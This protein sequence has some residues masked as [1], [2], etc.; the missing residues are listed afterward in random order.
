MNIYFNFWF[1]IIL[2]FIGLIIFSVKK[3]SLNLFAY[4]I[5]TLFTL[6]LVLNINNFNIDFFLVDSWKIIFI[7]LLTLSYFY[8]LFIL[9][10]N[11]EEIYFLVFMVWLGSLIVIISNHLLMVYLGLELQTF[12]LFVLIAKNRVSVKSSEAGLKYFVLGAI[13]SGFF[14]IVMTTIYGIYGSLDLNYLVSFHNSDFMFL[15]IILV[16]VLSLFFKLS[17]FPLHFWIPDIY[18]GS[19][20]DILGVLA[21]LPKISIMSLILQLNLPF[22]ILMWCAIGSII[23]G[24]FGGFN[25]TKIKRLLAYSGI[26]HIGFTFLG[27]A[28][29]SKIGLEVSLLYFIIYIVTVL[30]LITLLINHKGGKDKFISELSGIGLKNTSIGVVWAL[31]LLSIAGIPPLCGFLGKWWTIWTF[32]SHG[33]MFLGLVIVFASAIAVGYYLRVTKILYFQ[34]KSSYVIWN[35]VLQG[36]KLSFTVSFFLGLIFYFNLFLILNPNFLTELINYNFIDLF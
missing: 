15:V 30:G 26:S 32:V 14:L 8:I 1:F 17:L 16:L 19:A 24:S 31:L 34:P 20:S 3:E 6:I 33:H 36:N 10:D 25:Q 29:L 7:S 22:E 12:S 11:R 27:V 21:T 2:L 35:N 18:E 23:I 13:S 4:I 28:L 5:L 9:K